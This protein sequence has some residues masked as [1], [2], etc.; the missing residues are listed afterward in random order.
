MLHDYLAITTIYRLNFDSKNVKHALVIRRTLKMRLLSIFID[1]RSKGQHQL[2]DFFN[3][4]RAHKVFSI[5]FE[6]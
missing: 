3:G 1:T 6:N 4:F 2:V 5:A